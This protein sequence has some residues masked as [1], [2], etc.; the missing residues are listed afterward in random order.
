MSLQNPT[1]GEG[2]VAAGVGALLVA[3]LNSKN[4]GQTPATLW[5][6]P[7]G[8]VFSEV[9][10]ALGAIGYLRGG[11]DV[12]ATKITAIGGAGGLLA[13]ALGWS[14]NTPIGLMQP[15]AATPPLQSA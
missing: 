11:P 8:L 7:S 10:L 2:L 1:A 9:A 12:N 14:I 15:Q 3:L 5:G 13:Y 6:Q 4:P